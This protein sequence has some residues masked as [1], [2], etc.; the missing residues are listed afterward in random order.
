MD[1]ITDL[2]GHEPRE[3]VKGSEA[4]V[5]FKESLDTVL[6]ELII[7]PDIV[8]DY[9]EECKNGEEPVLAAAMAVFIESSDNPEVLLYE[10]SEYYSNLD[11]VIAEQEDDPK[12]RMH[13]YLK[14]V[15]Y[16]I[17]RPEYAPWGK[18][19]MQRQSTSEPKG[20]A[21]Q[22]K[23]VAVPKWFKTW[24]YSPSVSQKTRKDIATKLK[25]ASPAKAE[26]IIKDLQKIATKSG[27]IKRKPEDDKEA[28]EKDKRKKE[29]AGRLRKIS[30]F[31]KE[32]AGH[33]RAAGK[34][35]SVEQ[36]EDYEKAVRT[37]N[38]ICGP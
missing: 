32:I 28:D 26:R 31:S 37:V 36:I 20:M 15:G 17:D 24:L 3:R 33:I 5:M 23:K 30:D 21:G 16:K 12:K 19:S 10:I 7:F 38:D 29:V 2:V 34:K 27:V 4:K 22:R 8:D 14:R 11:G 1:F 25:T 13:D 6:S 35:P 18:K 9:Y